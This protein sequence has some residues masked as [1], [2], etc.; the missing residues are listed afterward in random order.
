MK[1]LAGSVGAVAVIAIGIFPAASGVTLGQEPTEH[2]ST[3]AVEVAESPST[4]VLDGDI[5][6][7]LQSR[8]RRGAPTVVNDDALDPNGTVSPTQ[9]SLIVEAFPRSMRDDR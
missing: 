8:G 4:K 6:R 5:S 1:G 7:R 2:G 9:Y 3:V